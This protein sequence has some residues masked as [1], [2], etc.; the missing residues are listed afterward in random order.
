VSGTL[1]RIESSIVLLRGLKVLL[2]VDLAALYGV[3]VK[4]L[5]QAVRRNAE[6]FPE[7]FMFQ[8]ALEEAGSLRSQMVTLET[9]RRGTHRE[10]LP[11][12]FTE[13][14]VA[15]LSSVLRSPRAIQMN[16]E[17]IRAFVRLRRMLQTNDEL[18]RRGLRERSERPSDSD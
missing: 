5:N 4:A 3:D 1:Q 14:G 15:M 17:I 16:I 10:Y 13:Q 9:P 8:L 11:Y 6:R 2:D 18:A 12:A 7:D